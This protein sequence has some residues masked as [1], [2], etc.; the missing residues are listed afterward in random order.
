L[1][2]LAALGKG[3][4]PNT[5]ISDDPIT[6]PPIGTGRVREQ[7]YWTPKNYDGFGGGILTLRRA[8]E[9][10]RNLAT[11]HLLEGGIED[12]AEASLDRLCR[13]A[14]EA[15]IYRECVRYYPFVLGAQPVR[16]IDL[17]AFYAAIA[18]EGLRPEPYLIDSIER[19]GLIVYRHDS[20]SSATIGSVDRA[21]FYQLKS[22]MQGVLARGTARSIAGLAPYVAG[23]TGTSDNENDAWFV[24]FTNDVTV[25]VWLGYDNADGKRRTLGGGATGGHVAVP[26][27]EPVIQAVWAHVAPR[28]ALAPPSPE[29]KRYLTCKAVDLQSGEMQ[30][31]GA[32]PINECLRIDSSGQ[33]VDTQYALVSRESAYYGSGYYGG[34]YYGGGYY[35]VAPNPNPFGYNGYYDQRPNNF[36]GYTYDGYGR[37][38]P[39]QRDPSRPPAQSYQPRDPRAQAAPQRD[40]YG[41]QYQYQNQN[42]FFSWGNRW[43][44]Y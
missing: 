29:A 25:A 44:F 22:M 24:G 40:P 19:N 15:Q 23:K 3:L 39:N 21:A 11:V 18:N 2:Y 30:G 36:Q 13:L 4:Q 31:Y 14:M 9:N 41:R 12:S 7:D 32:R 43:R 38:V 6:L 8:L 34:G 5:L 20:K 26:I 35:G 10:S 28:T 33:I 17:A 37:L 1:S 16:P 42:P 27:F